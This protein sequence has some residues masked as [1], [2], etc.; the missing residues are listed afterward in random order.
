MPLGLATAE[1][2][3]HGGLTVFIKRIVSGKGAR[4]S[5]NLRLS[6]SAHRCQ[7]AMPQA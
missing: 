1:N 2:E 7:M 6:S 4:S 5:Y 3:K